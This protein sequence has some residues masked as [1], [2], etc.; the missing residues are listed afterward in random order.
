MSIEKNKE[1]VRQW[2]S[3]I[4]Q[5]NWEDHI[6]ELSKAFN[7]PEEAQIFFDQH[8]EF[9][10]AF[11]NYQA[12]IDEMI[13][14]GNK[15]AIFQTVRVTHVGEFPYGELKGVAPTGKTLE[16]R[17]ANVVTLIDGKADTS[18]PPRFIVDGV[19]R[20]QQMGILPTVE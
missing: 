12:T 17:E 18:A 11:A 5:E 3:L 19:S 7:I 9:R 4:N 8:R 6:V 2:T 14:E 15:V 20:L 1:L 10:Q 16:W 13:A